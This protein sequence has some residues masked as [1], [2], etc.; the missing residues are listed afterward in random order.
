MNLDGLGEEQVH[1]LL[2]LIALNMIVFTA[3]IVK[4]QTEFAF[5]GLCA[6]F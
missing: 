3:L 2:M 5:S 1:T 4:V 6:L